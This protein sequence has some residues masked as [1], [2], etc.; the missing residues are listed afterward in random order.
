MS[1][2]PATEVKR[3]YTSTSRS[4]SSRTWTNCYSNGAHSCPKLQAFNYRNMEV[5]RSVRIEPEH[6]ACA[7][8]TPTPCHCHRAV[9]LFQKRFNS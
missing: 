3:S 9:K 6:S 5:A 2:Q 1:R 7:N 4:A 8:W